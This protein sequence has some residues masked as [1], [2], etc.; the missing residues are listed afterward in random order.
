MIV[1][2]AEWGSFTDKEGGLVGFCVSCVNGSDKMRAEFGNLC[3]K[4][5]GLMVVCALQLDRHSVCKPLHVML[6]LT[7]LVG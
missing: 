7:V 1:I 6:E 4:E 3:D 2:V 5:G